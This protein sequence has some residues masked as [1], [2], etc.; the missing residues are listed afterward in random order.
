MNDKYLYKLVIWIDKNIN[1]PENKAFIQKL[2]SL[3]YIKLYPVN[4]VPKA[5]NILKQIRFLQTYI[6][7][8]GLFYKEFIQ[9]YRKEFKRLRVLPKIIIFTSNSKIFLNNYSKGLPINDEIYNSGGVVDSFNLVLDFIFFEPFN[10][11]LMNNSQ[12]NLNRYMIIEYI[13]KDFNFMYVNQKEELIVPLFYQHLIKIPNDKEI[14]NFNY[15]LNDNYGEDKV[16]H[17]IM[18]QLLTEKLV[19]FPN[20]IICKY[21]IHLYTLESNFYK[22][23]NDDLRKGNF[24]QYSAFINSCYFSLQKSNLRCNIGRL[25]RGGVLNIKEINEIKKMIGKRNKNDIPNFLIFSKTFLS[26]S[27]DSTIA[28]K[29]IPQFVS[30]DF[31]PVMFVVDKG[32]SID[33]YN[34][35]NAEIS[36]YSYFPNEKEILFFPFS[37]FELSK[38]EYY[39][40]KY[41]CTLNY[42][43]KYKK[44]FPKDAIALLNEPQPNTL[45]SLNVQK[46]L[47]HKI[48]IKDNNI[49]KNEII[50]HKIFNEKL[51]VNSQI[52]PQNYNPNIFSEDYPFPKKNEKLNEDSIK[53][54][55]FEHF[56][57]K[58]LYKISI[59]GSNNNTIIC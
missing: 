55:N 9:S 48:P 18:K 49:Q 43:G 50:H 23:M 39:K 35:A 31:Q 58:Y 16:V 28:L 7:T 41:F 36:E 27:I 24:S 47:N 52:Y 14:Q 12:I 22:T 53:E 59:L 33:F 37:I 44:M 51:S 21:W 15:Y 45:F 2:E 11:N 42:L 54:E 8:S 34:I 38:I 46:I 5:I 29:F 32:S 40:D 10:L 20:G 25:Y 1:N 17:Q 6:I 30:S 4:E 57:N 3:K 56:D 13:E 26:F 19:N